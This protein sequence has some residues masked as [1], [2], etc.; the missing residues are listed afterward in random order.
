[1]NY[2]LTIAA[3]DSSGGAGIQQDLKVA[4]SLGYWGLSAIT[5]ITAQNFERI[6]SMQ[7]VSADMLQQQLD[8]CLRSFPIKAIKIGAI[9]S[10][11]N[12]DVIVECLKKYQPEKVVLDT[13]LSSTG[14]NKLFDKKASNILIKKL[15]PLTSLITPNK[16]EFEWLAK[17]NAETLEDAI[18]I[19]VKKCSEWE[20]SVLLKGGHFDDSHIREALV[21]KRGVYKMEKERTLFPYSH[22]TGCTLSSAIACYLGKGQSLLSACYSASDFLVMLFQKVNPYNTEQ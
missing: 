4:H 6:T 17:E 16:H 14:G 8:I 20:T 18:E 2:F 3:S 9:C 10:L 11:E 22:G 19:A 13:V 15:F 21:T 1:M 7:P 5:G 12:V